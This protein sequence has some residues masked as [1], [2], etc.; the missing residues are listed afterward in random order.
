MLQ[1]N[2]LSLAGF[3]GKGAVKA[4]VYI[5]ENGLASYLGT[6]LHHERHL[7]MLS[8]SKTRNTLHKYLSERTWNDL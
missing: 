8:D 3:Y 1:I 6:D 5:L 4:A 7:M 2:L